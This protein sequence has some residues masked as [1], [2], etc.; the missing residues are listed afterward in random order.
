[1]NRWILKLLVLVALS[2]IMACSGGATGGVIPN[3]GSSNNLAATFQPDLATPTSGSVSLQPGNASGNTVTV[4][5]QA[6]DVNDVYAASFDVVIDPTM[7]SYVGYTAGTLLESDG[8]SVQYQITPAGSNRYVVGVT[9]L[10]AT[11]GVNA[12]GRQDLL[13]LTFRATNAGTSS[14]SLSN[15]SLLDG[16]A[17]PAP[18]PNLTWAAGSVV[19]N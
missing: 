12:V 18:I 16:Q 1:M 4:L 6:T 17:T 3:D 5:V 8:A 11:T 7:V 13:R 10:G 15:A 19:A 2:T 9:R 14:I